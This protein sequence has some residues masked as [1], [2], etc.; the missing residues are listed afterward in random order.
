M[1][2]RS[3][4]RKLAELSNKKTIGKILHRNQISF[5]D[6]LESCRNVYVEIRKTRRKVVEKLIFKQK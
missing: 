6:R 5:C 3:E 4:C 2:L 1:T